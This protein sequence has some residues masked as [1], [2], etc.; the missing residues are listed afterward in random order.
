MVL[1]KGNSEAAPAVSSGVIRVGFAKCT[2]HEK[3][4][5]KGC[6]GNTGHR[7]MDATHNCTGSEARS[8]AT[9]RG[10]CSRVSPFTVTQLLRRF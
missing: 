4:S 6:T 10:S 9:R 1:L 7:L 3:C 5:Q 2:A 8:P